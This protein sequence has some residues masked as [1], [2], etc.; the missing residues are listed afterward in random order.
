MLLFFS[1]FVVTNILFSVILCSVFIRLN[2]DGKHSNL[3]LL[4]HSLGLGPAFTT[5]LLY[6]SFLLV[7]HRSNVFYLLLIAGV[8]FLL[9]VTGR[10]SFEP[11]YKNIK[12]NIRN[13]FRIFRKPVFRK[14]E[15]IILITIICVPLALYLFVYLTKIL[16][17][18]LI[19]HDILNYGIMGRILFEEKSLAPIWVKN[20]ANSGFLYGILH[21][22]S[23]SLL[24]TWEEL[25]NSFFHVKSDL[26]FKSI[27]SY[28][29][30]LIL[31]TQYYWIA[32]KNKWLAILAAIALL[33]GLA[34]F[35]ILFSKHIDSYRILLFG[36]SWIYLA[37]AIKEKDFLSLL[38][39]GIFSGFAAFAHR[40]GVVLAV[41]NCISFCIIS[42]SNFKTRVI[43]TTI[44]I[45]L[46]L[47]F[48]GS[49][50]VFDIIWGQGFWLPRFWK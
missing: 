47:A 29:G 33:S 40:I 18:P 30:L 15:N 46:I 37:Y 32:K 5:L 13:L 6:Y 22:P 17:Q 27:S 19:G 38:M 16:H 45:I 9:A 8:Y 49:H 24:L 3:G 43:R 39:F 44:V 36:I 28:Y 31:G 10:K 21:A 34:F 12:S 48:G 35:L 2:K 25:V 4:L 41:I 14:I 11:L 20:F 50:Y 1:K 7:P 42:K 23:F 26:Y